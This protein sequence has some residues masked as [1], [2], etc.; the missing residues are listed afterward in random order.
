MENDTTPNS[1]TLIASLYLWGARVVGTIL[2][3]GVMLRL[4][5]L[6]VGPENKETTG[7]FGLWPNLALVGLWVVPVASIAIAG[8]AWVRRDR[9][10][11]TGWLAI[12]IGVFLTSLWALR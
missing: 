6:L 4:G 10:D 9:R 3:I 7:I 11:W 5:W 1:N 2:L 12:V 8:V